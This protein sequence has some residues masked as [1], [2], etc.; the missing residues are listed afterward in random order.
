MYLFGG[1]KYITLL[2]F[3]KNNLGIFLSIYLV[4]IFRKS[5]DFLNF[6][7][8]QTITNRKYTKINIETFRATFNF[9]NEAFVSLSFLA[10]FLTPI[11]ITI[12]L[13]F[14]F[15]KSCK[16][17]L[18]KL[19]NIFMMSQDRNNNRK[20]AMQQNNNYNNNHIKYTKNFGGNSY[21]LKKKKILRTFTFYTVPF[22]KKRWDLA[23][24]RGPPTLATWLSRWKGIHFVD[25]AIQAHMLDLSRQAGYFQGRAEMGEQINHMQNV[26]FAET[27]A[28]VQALGAQSVETARQEGEANARTIQDRFTSLSAELASVSRENAELK[29]LFQQER[30]ATQNMVLREMGTIKDLIAASEQRSREL[31]SSSISRLESD[32]E[33]RLQRL[34]TDLPR[35]SALESLCNS[36]AESLRNAT[37]STDLASGFQHLLGQLAQVKTDFSTQLQTQAATT[38]ELTT[39]LSRVKFSQ[40]ARMS[41]FEKELELISSHTKALEI[42]AV[43]LKNLKTA[44]TKKQRF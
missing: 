4:V 31:L 14:A 15:R 39:G 21:L 37:D 9:S 12:I 11:H 2:H 36:T 8:S 38:K 26:H 33:S 22:C 30:L 16:A 10:I 24:P 19:G 5:N 7:Q 27:L 3:L 29:H 23:I 6:F 1:G 43:E 34:E 35:V 13:Q 42:I 44:M 41:Q 20:K 28:A 17:R 40:A 32:F 18:R 25:P